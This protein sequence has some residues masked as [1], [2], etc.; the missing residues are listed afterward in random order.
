MRQ[1]LFGWI[2]FQ[3]V[4]MECNI[5]TECTFPVTKPR[6][7]TRTAYLAEQLE[8]YISVHPDKRIISV[9]TRK[10]KVNSAHFA[11]VYESADGAADLRGED[12]SMII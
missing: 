8:G 6:G 1:F 7:S 4:N 12:H 10:V 11:D 5:E 3:P 2:G 9:F